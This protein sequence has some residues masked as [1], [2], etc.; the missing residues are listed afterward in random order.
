LKEGGDDRRFRIVAVPK[1]VHLLAVAD[2]DGR[3]RG[4]GGDA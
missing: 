1:Q 2:A 4:A 3:L